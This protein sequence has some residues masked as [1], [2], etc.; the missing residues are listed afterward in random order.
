MR[1]GADSVCVAGESA[2]EGEGSGVHLLARLLTVQLQHGWGDDGTAAVYGARAA[3]QPKNGQQT[4]LYN[5]R[6]GGG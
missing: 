2:W 4:G 3:S 6:G 1:K 5:G